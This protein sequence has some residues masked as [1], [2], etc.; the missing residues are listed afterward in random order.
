W[1]LTE[2]QRMAPEPKRRKSWL[3]PLLWGGLVAVIALAGCEMDSFLDPSVVGR[4]ERTPVVLPILDRLDVIDEPPARVQGMT[5]V[6]PED[7]VPDINEYV[8]GA[9]DLVTVTVFELVQP[10]VE[11]V[12]T[13]RLDEL[14]VVRLPE[15]GAIKAAGL[16]PSQLEKK[17]GETLEAK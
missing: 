5:S 13:R 1:R 11:S 6:A 4:W 8:M 14:G 9:G 2:P 7:L 15:I 10:G 3:S 16:T 17:I 12:Q